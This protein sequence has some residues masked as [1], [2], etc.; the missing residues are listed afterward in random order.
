MFLGL[1]SKS[2]IKQSNHD[3]CHI[4]YLMPFF[5]RT[6]FINLP[7]LIMIANVTLAERK[8]FRQKIQ[9]ASLLFMF[10][11]VIAKV[12]ILQPHLWFFQRPLCCCCFSN[13]RANSDDTVVTLELLG[14]LISFLYIYNSWMLWC[15]SIQGCGDFG[16]R[17]LDTDK[18]K[19]SSFYY[20]F[21]GFIT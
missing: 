14:Y 19:W 15:T 12:F 1:G 9:K 6:T 20:S 11:F 8:N 3:H 16:M 21:I 4:S 10:I 18:L 17:F 7:E 13:L 2:F 5:L